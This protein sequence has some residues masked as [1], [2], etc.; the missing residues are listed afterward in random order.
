MDDPDIVNRIKRRVEIMKPR[1]GGC[2]VI[3]DPGEEVDFAKPAE[4]I[5]VI[6][7]ETE[8]PRSLLVTPKIAQFSRGFSLMFSLF[9]LKVPA[10]PKPKNFFYPH[11]KNRILKLF[12]PFFL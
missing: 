1:H 5:D 3:M 6:S 10:G 2:L 9:F 4:T 11:K 8:K 12:F 7:F